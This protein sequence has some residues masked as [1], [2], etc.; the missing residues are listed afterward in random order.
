MFLDFCPS[1]NSDNTWVLFKTSMFL[2][3]FCGSTRSLL[4]KSVSTPFVLQN[5][6]SEWNL[7]LMKLILAG[8]TRHVENGELCSVAGQKPQKQV[9]KLNIF[10]SV[11]VMTVASFSPELN[12][13]KYS[14]PKR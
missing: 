1:G 2:V 5:D 8:S 11:L 4:Y 10:L 7:M 9:Q 14:S 6:I 12:K 3:I 13:N